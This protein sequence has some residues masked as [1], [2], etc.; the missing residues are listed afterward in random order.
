MPLTKQMPVDQARTL[1]RAGMDALRRGDSRSARRSFESIVAGGV[2]DASACVA[3]ALA[4]RGLGD[5]PAALAAVDRALGHEPRNLRALVVKADLL[6]DLGDVR[7][8]SSF[9]LAAVTL[10][11]SAGEVPADLR[12]EI[13]RAKA[14]VEKSTAQ[15]EESVRERL[16]AAG[17]LA[18]R[19]AGRFTQS[20][21]IFFGRKQV[22]FQQ[23]RYYFFPGLPQ[24]Q[25]YDRDAFPWLDRVE[26][27][28]D[29]IRAELV[30]ILKEESAFSPYVQSDSRTPRKEQD[31]ML[32]NPDWSAFYLWKNG[33]I[34]PENA[35]RAPTAL[36]AL[37]G[38]PIARVANR[39][40]SI[41]FSLLKP[42]AH[43]PPHC[44]LVNTRLIC[45]LPIVVPGRCVFRVGNEIREWEEGK[46]WAF[47][48][49]IEHEAW[50]HS[51]GHA[52]DPAL[53]GLAARTL[54]GGARAGRVRC[55]RRSTP[56]RASG[57]RGK[58]RRGGPD[59]C[60][61]I[62]LAAF[63]PGS[64]GTTIGA[65]LR[66]RQPIVLAGRRTKCFPASGGPRSRATRLRV[67]ASECSTSPAET[68]R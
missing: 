18:S 25:F 14:S 35:A 55:S 16:K 11:A 3:L 8:S 13:E 65:S 12:A 48:D 64:P 22:H 29:K 53:R 23:P 61:T 38:A 32:D 62:P 24:I 51:D 46:A 50:N 43:I 57:R 60:P 27:A 5:G 9:Y 30:D 52:R 4:C 15:I 39:S 7:A 20:L 45:H 19:F 2:D 28:T 47:D 17:L 66:R 21:D 54:R 42:G 1:A 36:E 41:L 67:R 44:G 10:A 26:A 59:G 6:A 49:T 68:A 56:S 33:E 58:S 63:R 40:P 34:V 31:G 37:A